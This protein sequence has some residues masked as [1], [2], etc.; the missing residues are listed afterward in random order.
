MTGFARQHSLL[1]PNMLIDFLTFCRATLLFG[2]HFLLALKSI[3]KKFFSNSHCSSF[4]EY[5]ENFQL[6]FYSTKIKTG[7][8]PLWLLLLPL[9][10]F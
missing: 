5:K 7:L 4:H 8:D 9:F 10:N 3:E 2:Q 1:A 6:Q